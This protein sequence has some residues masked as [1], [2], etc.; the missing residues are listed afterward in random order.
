MTVDLRHAGA[1]RYL[2]FSP[3]PI[4][5]N[6]VCGYRQGQPVDRSHWR[7]SNLFLPFGE[8]YTRVAQT[9][10]ASFTLPHISK[11]AYLCIAINGVHGVEGA[12]AGCKVGDEYVGCPDRAPSFA[13]NT[14]EHAV[15]P[16]D[17]NYTY[18]LS[19]TPDMQ[20]KKITAYVMAFDKDRCRLQPQMWL[21]AYP[22]P[23]QRRIDQIK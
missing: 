12:W 6:E 20:G 5:L 9:W 1:V 2:R 7:A 4:R 13:A 21:T 17:S 15:T 8:R 19:L 22:I 14:W 3:C 18:Y 10:S 23:F 11:G 16:R